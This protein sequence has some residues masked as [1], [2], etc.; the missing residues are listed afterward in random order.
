ME[1][2]RSSMTC[3]NLSH[4]RSVEVIFVLKSV[5]DARKLK[6]CLWNV[7]RCCCWRKLGSPEPGSRS[8]TNIAVFPAPS[9]GPHPRFNP[10]LTRTKKR[11]RVALSNK[12]V[13]YS[14]YGALIFL[15]NFS[16]EMATPHFI[17]FR[18][19]HHY[20]TRLLHFLDTSNKKKRKSL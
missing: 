4:L 7:H 16:P 1:S 5:N 13:Y 8:R 17:F 2:T 12:V 9:F 20:F 19:L 14:S 15:G 3:D 11:F 10:D 6:S 18:H